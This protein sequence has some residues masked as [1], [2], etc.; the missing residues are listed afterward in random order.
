MSAK[1]RYDNHSKEGCARVYYHRKFNMI[2]SYTVECGYFGP[3]KLNPFPPMR[4]HPIPGSDYECTRDWEEVSKGEYSPNSYKML[5]KSLL[6]SIIDL[7]HINPYTRIG[8]SDFKSIN[9]LRKYTAQKVYNEVERFR[10]VDSNC[11]RKIRDV[12]RMIEEEYYLPRFKHYGL[13]ISENFGMK[14]RKKTFSINARLYPTRSLQ[15]LHA[16]S[17]INDSQQ[18]QPSQDQSQIREVETSREGEAVE[19]EKFMGIHINSFTDHSLT[20]ELSHHSF[21]TKLLKKTT[22]MNHRL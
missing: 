7:F 8:T 16:R 19:E 5:G 9:S 18:I 10:L 15:S 17:R 3:T 4:E 13:N 1:E 11:Y 21:S 6:I 12:A 2:H 20:N 22:E 14:Y